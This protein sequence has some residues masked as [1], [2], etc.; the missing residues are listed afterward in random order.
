MPLPE[1]RQ[2][3]E[4]SGMFYLVGNTSAVVLCAEYGGTRF[5]RTVG[6]CKLT[7]RNIP[8]DKNRQRH[9]QRLKSR[10]RI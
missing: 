5:L 9:S 6:Y 4:H 7:R 3:F 2:S 8:E 1:A 10:V